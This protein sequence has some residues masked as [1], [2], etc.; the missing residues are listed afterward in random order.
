[1]PAVLAMSIFRPGALRWLARPPLGPSTKSIGYQNNITNIEQHERQ[2][3]TTVATRKETNYKFQDVQAYFI[4][5]LPFHRLYNP[6]LIP[7]SSEVLRCTGAPEL[8]HQRNMLPAAAQLVE[9]RSFPA[10]HG[11]AQWAQSA[12]ISLVNNTGQCSGQRKKI[13]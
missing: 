4:M 5:F 9:P 7:C 12:W 13:L 2:I 1:M 8:P 10:T 11:M 6:F 3:A